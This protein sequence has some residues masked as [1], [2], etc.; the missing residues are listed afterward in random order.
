MIEIKTIKDW[1]SKSSV[2]NWV[3]VLLLVLWILA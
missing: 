2:P 3:L 1:L